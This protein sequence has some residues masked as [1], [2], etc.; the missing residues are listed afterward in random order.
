MPSSHLDFE[1]HEL[2]DHLQSEEDCEGHVE[3]V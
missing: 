3:D 1:G 2:E